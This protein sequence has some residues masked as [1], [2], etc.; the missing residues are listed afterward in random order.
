MKTGILLL[1]LWPFFAPAQDIALVDRELKRPMLVTQELTPEQLSGKYFPIYTSDLDSVIQM[2]EGLT[3]FINTGM[4][5]DNNMQLLPVGHSQFAITILRAGSF[6]SYMVFLSTR[7]EN[8]G[9]TLELVKRHDSSRQALH[10]LFL[11]L[12]YLKNNRHMVG[13]QDSR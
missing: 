4:V 8:L 6:N 1:L 11:F 5:H 7:C 13:K 12:D 2:I 3:G 10:E 9:A